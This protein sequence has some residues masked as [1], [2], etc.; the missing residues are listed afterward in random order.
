VQANIGQFIQFAF[1]VDCAL[2]II[3][4]CALALTTS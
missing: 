3:Y 1:F 4:S 2:A